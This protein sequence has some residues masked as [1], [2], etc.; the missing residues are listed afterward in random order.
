MPSDVQGL[1]MCN[2]LLELTFPLEIRREVTEKTEI[3]LNTP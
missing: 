2:S 3:Q 1:N